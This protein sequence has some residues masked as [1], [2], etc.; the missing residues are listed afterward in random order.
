MMLPELKLVAELADREFRGHTFNGYSLMET[1]NSLRAEEAVSTDSYEGY[2]AWSILAHCVYYKFYL[3]RFLGLSGA[4]EPYRWN[5][6]SFPVIPDQS[7]QAWEDARAYANEVHEAFLAMLQDLEARQFELK[8]PAWD[9]TV[10]EAILWLPAHDS[11]HN[12]QIRNM[13][14]KSLRKPREA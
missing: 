11:I 9:C 8:I 7:E 1:V 3:L 14:I 10:Q 5:E 13:G 12:G 2:S 6:D 4:V